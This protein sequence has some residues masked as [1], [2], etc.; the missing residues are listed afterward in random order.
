FVVSLMAATRPQ[1]ITA[2]VLVNATPG[3]TAEPFRRWG[4]VA[5]AIDRLG[6]EIETSWGTVEATW[7]IPLFA[8]SAADDVRYREWLARALRQSLSPATAKALFDVLFFNDIRNVLPAIRVPTL[9]IHRRGNRYLEPQHGRYLAE[10]I[11]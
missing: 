1:R 8:P 10:H 7:G 2:L 9:V 3:F 11:P 5:G 4:L 6:S